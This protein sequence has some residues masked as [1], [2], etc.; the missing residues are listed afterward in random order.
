L[1]NQR[2]WLGFIGWLSIVGFMASVAVAYGAAAGA[3]AG[4]WTAAIG[5]VATPIVGISMSTRIRIVGG[6]EPILHVGRA[7]IPLSACGEA[8]VLDST[9]LTQIRRDDRAAQAHWAAPGWCR[10]GIACAVTDDTDP[11]L[12]WVVG[13]HQPQALAAAINQHRRNSA[14][15][16]TMSA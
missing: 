11:H 3:N 8:R 16:G 12:F 7:H 4:W 10:Q 9:A 5:A 2:Q 15:H 13:S 14:T 1:F 6:R